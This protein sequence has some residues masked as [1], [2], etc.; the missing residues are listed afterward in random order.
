MASSPSALT[1]FARDYKV[2]LRAG[3]V[4]A[5]DVLTD[6]QRHRAA[7]ELWEK[8]RGETLTIDDMF[9]LGSGRTRNQI[10]TICLAAE[11][12]GFG[13]FDPETNRM[14]WFVVRVSQSVELTL[15]LI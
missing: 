5:G 14:E 2:A 11:E 12:S 6:P 3:T 8:Y 13:V 15:G 9:A 10:R 7:A 1:A 4:A